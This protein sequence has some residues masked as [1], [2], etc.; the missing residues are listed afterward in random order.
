MLVLELF[1]EWALEL[2][3]V[4]VRV[5]VGDW[6]MGSVRGWVFVVLGQK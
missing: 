1:E 3:R 2:V 6:V 5:M 4:L